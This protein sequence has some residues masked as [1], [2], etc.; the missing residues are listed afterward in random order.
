MRGRSKGETLASLEGHLACSRVP[1]LVCFSVGEWRSRREA[2]LAAVAAALPVPRVAVRSSARC[3]D[4]PGASLAGCFLSLLGVA[5]S[6]DALVVAVEAVVASLGA[7][8]ANQVIVQAMVEDVAAS[9][10]ILTREAETGAPYYVIEYD[11]ASGR[12]DRVTSGA[13]VERSAVL[14]RNTPAR[15]LPG[16]RLGRFLRATREIERRWRRQALELEVAETAQAEVALLQVRALAAEPDGDVAL[17]VGK[18]LEQLAE[19]VRERNCPRPGLAGSRT[20][21]GQMPDWNPAELIGPRPSP[22]A[23][24]LFRRL[25]SDSVWQ[26]ARSAMGYRPV[27]DEPLVLFLLGRP[28]VD[29]RSSFNSFLPAGLPAPAAIA[30][31]DAWLGRLHDRPELHDKVEVDVAQTVLDFAFHESHRARFGGALCPRDLADY[32]DR[33]GRL[34]RAILQP[35]GPSSLARA[36]AAVE[37]LEWERSPLAHGDAGAS[38]GYALE[39]LRACR[40]DGT[41]PFA[42]VARH[43]FVAEA[44]LRSAV[45]RGAWTSERMHAFKRSIETVATYLA[46]DLAAV[47][48]G[49]RSRR[50]FLARYGHVRPGTF[51]VT[52]PRY[53]QREDLFAHADPAR[54]AA[55]GGDRS[56]TPTPRELENLDRLCRES[57]LALG[58]E[59]LLRHARLAIAGRERAKFLVARH[60]SDALECLAGWAARG[61]LARDTLSYLTL[62]DLLDEVGEPASESRSGYLAA[63]A[64]ARRSLDEEMRPVRLGP[65]IRDVRDLYVQIEHPTSPTFVTSRSVTAPTVRLERPMPESP[66]VRGRLVCIESADPGFDWIFAAGIAGLLT[67][68][69]GGNSHM[70]IRCHE[71][72]TPA[73]IGLG[74]RWFEHLAHG[75]VAELRCGERTV[76]PVWPSASA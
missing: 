68:F 3:E 7:D 8:P 70:A 61:N 39:L 14:Y 46:H 69:G 33:L 43:A 38:L 31:V 64:R 11:T 23:A 29:V 74:E 76:R 48:A 37:R 2:V 56:F 21:L 67:K 30:L 25:V 65:L 22:L 5:S 72:D 28:Y 36:M 55:S 27:P 42:A 54:F 40:A 41:R 19:I 24:S 52:S 26:E 35:A 73:A 62:E 15:W 32:A 57:E 20:I 50:A 53:D 6:A 12:T 34:T 1:P 66:A 9:G 51:D 63:L 18:A 4:R 13:A 44:L 17:R 49:R 58:G 60:L 75:P 16:G 45:E 71:L 47:A 10:V 59:A